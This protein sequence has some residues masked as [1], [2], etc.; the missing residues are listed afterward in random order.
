MVLFPF[1]SIPV[2]RQLERKAVLIIAT[3]VVTTL[4][5]SLR[6]LLAAV[7]K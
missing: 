7:E 6:I 1:V 3:Q 5:K 2:V 4:V